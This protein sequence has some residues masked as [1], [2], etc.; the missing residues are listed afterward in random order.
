MASQIVNT[1]ALNIDVS[2]PV[3]LT[4]V[5]LHCVTIPM[6]TVKKPRSC[7]H[8]SCNKCANFNFEGEKKGQILCNTQTTWND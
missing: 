4:P 8:D 2:V 7:D 6:Q 5:A 3:P 1:D